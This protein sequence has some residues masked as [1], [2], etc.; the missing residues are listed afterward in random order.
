MLSI[1]YAIW[2]SWRMPS[3]RIGRFGLQ[4]GLKRLAPWLPH[5]EGLALQP[6]VFELGKWWEMMRKHWISMDLGGTTGH[7]FSDKS[8]HFRQGWRSFKNCQQLNAYVFFLFS[9]VRG[10]KLRVSESQVKRY[11][12][13]LCSVPN[14][15][16]K[17]APPLFVIAVA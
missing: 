2:P 15:A 6:A 8:W 1:W 5:V 13:K 17:W 4:I 12:Q 7:P 16:H 9:Q 10:F 14:Q 3:T 11:I